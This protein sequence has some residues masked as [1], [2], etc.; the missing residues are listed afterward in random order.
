MALIDILVVGLVLAVVVS[1][2]MGFKLP[3]DPRPRK[4]RKGDLARLGQRMMAAEAQSSGKKVKAA[5]EVKPDVSG[6]KGIA[7]LQ[8]LDNQ[9]DERDFKDGTAQAYKYFYQSWN[10]MDVAALDKLCGPALLEQLEASLDDYRDR[11]AKPQVVVNEVRDV[12]II[13]ADVKAMTAVVEARITA[14]QSEDEVVAKRGATQ[15]LPHEVV[16]TWVLARA[17]GSDDPN[18]ELQ[19][20]RHEGGRA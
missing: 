12:E 7:K 16:V 11:G 4:N 10:A 9:F 6:L 5:K 1:R 13:K 3:H 18:W 14:L 17:L 15:A 19:Q 20:I 2:F 8:A